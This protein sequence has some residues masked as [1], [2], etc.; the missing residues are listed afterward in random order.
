MPKR[1]ELRGGATIS[2]PFVRY[3]CSF[4]MFVGTNEKSA[5]CA[6]LLGSH[7]RRYVLL[8][9]SRESFFADIP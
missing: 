4:Y 6:D 1:P 3:R 7:D 2:E 5:V 8:D 9:R